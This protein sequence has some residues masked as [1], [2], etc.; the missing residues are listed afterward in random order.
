MAM[1]STAFGAKDEIDHVIKS[2]FTNVNKKANSQLGRVIPFS[3]LIWLQ[4]SAPPPLVG[5]LHAC[6]SIV[7]SVAGLRPVSLHSVGL[8]S[9]V[10]RQVFDGA[11]PS[12]FAMK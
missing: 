7:Y 3:S 4:A 5:S 9:P 10:T 6:A 11:E 8:T 1:A 12:I 2:T